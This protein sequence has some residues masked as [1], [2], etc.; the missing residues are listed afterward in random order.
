MP[1][2][3]RTLNVPTGAICGTEK[4]HATSP[5]ASIARRRLNLVGALGRQPADLLVKAASPAALWE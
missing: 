1:D 2:P 4:Y 3:T 5:P